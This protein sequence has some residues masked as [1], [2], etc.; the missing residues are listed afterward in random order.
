M[1]GRGHVAHLSSQK[2]LYWRARPTK[3]SCKE[4]DDSSGMYIN[5]SQ[6]NDNNKS[7]EM[8]ARRATDNPHR[9]AKR[10]VRG[11]STCPCSPPPFHPKHTTL[12]LLAARLNEQRLLFKPTQRQPN[13]IIFS[14]FAT[15][16][17]AIFILSLTP[18]ECVIPPHLPWRSKRHRFPFNP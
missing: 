4:V 17:C 15:H 2:Q 14:P 12:D 5:I 3:R 8:E 9:Y 11:M 10:G 16:H 18:R 7:V 6:L 13:S 1:G